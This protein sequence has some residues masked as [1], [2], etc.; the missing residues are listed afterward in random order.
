LRFDEVS[1]W[2]VFVE[3]RYSLRAALAPPVSLAHLLRRGR[4]IAQA[5][6]Q[7]PHAVGGDSPYLQQTL[8]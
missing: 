4:C 2:N 7:T 8:G 3:V 1:R 5:A 6:A